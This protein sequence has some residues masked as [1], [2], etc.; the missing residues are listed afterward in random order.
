MKKLFLVLLFLGWFNLR[1]VARTGHAFLEINPAAV[2]AGLGGGGSALA[3]GPFAAWINPAA[4]ERGEAGFFLKNWLLDER[5]LGTAAGKELLPDTRVS[6]LFYSSTISDLVQRSGPESGGGG[7]FEAED[8]VGGLTVSHTL[9]A[10]ISVGATVK[11]VLERIYDAEAHGWA[12]DLGLRYRWRWL[13][14]G[15]SLS[16]LG[17]MSAL[18]TTS[19]QLPNKLRLGLAVP[20]D[21]G[22]LQ[23]RSTFDAVYTRYHGSVDDAAEMMETLGLQLILRRR[24]IFRGAFILGHPT[25]HFSLGLGLRLRRWSFDY[26][27]VP[28]EKLGD[29]S[30][31][32][33]R[34][35]FSVNQ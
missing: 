3:G 35:E 19:S 14:S 7:T 26:A 17:R 1:A 34:Y 8:F 31:F 2:S 16:N 6:V 15:A 24:I 12:L 10:G 20:F 13:E 30:H 9:G 27:F 33:I 25:R 18:E 5:L 29:T 21:L 23:A 22:L 32:S 4:V 28:V 11:Y